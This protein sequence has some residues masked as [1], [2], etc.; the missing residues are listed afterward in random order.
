[1]LVALLA[2]PVHGLTVLCTPRPALTVKQHHSTARTSGCVLH[3]L[4]AS[5]SRGVHMMASPDEERKA[6]AERKEAL[7]G[8]GIM[9]GLFGGTF[10]FYYVLT[11]LGGVDEVLAGQLVLLAL[12]GF[13]AFLVF[14]DG[15]ATQAALESSAVQQMAADEGELMRPAPREVPPTRTAAATTAEP[16]AAAATLR[17]EGLLRVDGLVP[18]EA[19]AA[20]VEHVEKRLQAGRVA[21]KEDE[22]REY[23]YFGAVLCRNNRYDLK[24]ALEPVVEAVLLPVVEQL[25]PLLTELLPDAEL[26]EL[27]A[28]VSDPGAPR[29]PVHPD[30]GYKEGIEEPAVLTGFLALQDV[31]EDMGPTVFLPRTHF[32]P[33]H[34]RF[35]DAEGDGKN[36]LLKGAPQAF[37][38]LGRG[39]MS[40][41]D[42]RLLHCGAANLS[43]KRRIL[44]YFSFKAG[45]QRPPPGTI[46]AALRAPH[47][48]SG[49]HLPVPPPPPHPGPALAL[50]V[51]AAQWPL[52]AL[53]TPQWGLRFSTASRP[54]RPGLQPG[55]QPPEPATLPTPRRGTKLDELVK[56]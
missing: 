1:M 12:V 35:N 46:L 18:P 20:L 14:F 17:T 8:L 32:A 26:F 28:L 48:Q 36:E 21:V 41:F 56:A 34:A 2:S 27:A 40:L 16:A 11:S 51:R 39:D 42:S 29:Q 31:D 15:G 52:A 19:T 3:S 45:N 24:L 6:T 30:T 55:S 43:K 22:M 23:Q 50:L 9:S 4:A 5:R 33:V 53:R 54:S 47:V 13:G 7:L 25:R 10:G 49:R 37:G 38:V 44:F